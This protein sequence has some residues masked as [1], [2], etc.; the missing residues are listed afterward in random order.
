MPHLPGPD[1]FYDILG[2]CGTV[3]FLAAYLLLQTQRIDP[4]GLRYSLM[5]LAGAV[6][7]LLSLLH[8][9]NL[10]AFMLELAWGAISLYGIVQSLKRN[11]AKRNTLKTNGMPR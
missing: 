11:G 6:L 3:A 10:S 4:A 5:N 2:L 7:I 9:W 8:S 1:F